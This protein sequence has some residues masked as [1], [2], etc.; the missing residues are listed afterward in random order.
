M[1]IGNT[2]LQ[3]AIKR[4][5]YYK[6]LGDQTIEQLSDAEMHVQP[7]PASNNMAMLIQHMAGNMLSRS[8]DFLQSDGEKDWRNRDAEFEDSNLD[9]DGLV[10]LW[11]KGWKCFLDTLESLNEDDLLKTIRIRSE[12][13]SVIDA[14]NRQ[15]AHYPCHVGQMIY[16]GKIIRDEEWKNLSIAKGNSAE[17]NRQMWAKS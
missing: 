4:V 9:K 6:L 10:A 17:F 5:R 8:T 14:I 3:S 7:N 11:E 12:Q 1:S 16:L 15:L 13:L 2:F